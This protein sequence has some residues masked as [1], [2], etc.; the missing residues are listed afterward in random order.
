MDIDR[1]TI[2][3]RN[4]HMKEN[5][6][7]NCH[8]IGHRA[9]D[10]RQKGLNNLSKSTTDEPKQNNERALIKYEG[11][12][13]PNTARALIRNIVSD[14]EEQDKKTLFNNMLEDEDF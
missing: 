12:N 13:T 7:F 11:K 4:K 9:K 14:M 3:E 2:E 10:C 5:R 1:M 6:C 8:K